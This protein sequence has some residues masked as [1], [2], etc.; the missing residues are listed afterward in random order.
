MV[1]ISLGVLACAE[2]LNAAPNITYET[3]ADATRRT[4]IVDLAYSCAVVQH[5]MDD[6]PAGFCRCSSGAPPG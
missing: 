6:T 3:P 2:V 4:D 1:D 5:L